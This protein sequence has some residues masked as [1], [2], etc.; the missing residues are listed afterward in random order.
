MFGLVNISPAISSLNAAFK[1]SISTKPSSVD[2]ISII[3]KPATLAD[4]GFVPWAES[5]TIILVLLVSPLCSWYAFIKAKP[6]SSPW[7]PAAGCKVILSIPDISHKAWS[8]SYIN[9]S[10]PCTV[11]SGWSGW[12]FLKPSR[13]AMSSLIFGLYFM[14]Q[15]PRG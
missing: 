4:A 5:G 10:A 9:L 13:P 12:I 1:L 11:S 14:V 2:L 3:S 8:N 7:A 15:E 6:V